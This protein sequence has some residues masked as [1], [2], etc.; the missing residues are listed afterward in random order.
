M[1]NNVGLFITE[2]NEGEN[3]EKASAYIE[4][5]GLSCYTSESELQANLM[6]LESIIKEGTQYRTR[7]N[8]S[9]LA[10]GTRTVSSI[11]TFVFTDSRQTADRMKASGIGFAVYDNALSKSESFSDSLYMVDEISAIP[12]RQVERMLLRFLRLPWTILET[13]RCRVREI[14]EEDVPALYTIYDRSDPENQYGGVPY[15]DPEKELAYTKDYINFQY[16]LF[17]YGVWVVEDKE[18]GKIIGRAGISNRAGYE[19]AELGYGFAPSAR[20]RGYATEVCGAILSYA[21][22]EL[23]M[24]TINAFTLHDNADSVKLLKRLGFKY[25]SK[26]DLSGVQ[27]DLYRW[28]C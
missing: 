11:D 21:H 22:E 12:L 16:R 14:T 4:S 25:V 6:P 8:M 3:L 24:D 13:K 23:G 27:Y 15:E 9:V 26:K 10:P 1:I 7:N 5:L 18:S 20:H 17:E 28:R 19:E 2:Y